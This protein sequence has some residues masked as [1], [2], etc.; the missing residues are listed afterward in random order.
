MIDWWENI[1]FAEQWVLWLLPAVPVFAILLYYIGGRGRPALTLSSFRYL[2]GIR[3]PS[4]VKWRSVLY[5]IRFIIVIVLITAFARPQ[6]RTGF[7]RKHGQGIDIMLC[8]DIS[9][10]METSDDGIGKSSRIESAREQALHFVDQRPD[11]RIGVVIFSGEAFTV[12]PLTTDH[13][14]LKL[15]IGQIDI[16]D[17]SLEQ[18]T[19]IGMGL[20]KAVERIK[21]SKAKSKVIILL[22][23]GENGKGT[24]QPID[25]ARMAKTFGI[26]VYTIGLGASAGKVMAPI[27][28]NPDGSPNYAFQD[29]DIDEQTLMDMASTTGG[30]YFRASDSKNLK[31]VYEEINDLEK[32]DFD[33]N[34]TEQRKEEFLPFLIA[35]L[36]FV[37]LEFSLRYTTFDSL[38]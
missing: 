30:K 20:A 6:S 14:A 3:V 37:L 2:H 10:S 23:D 21:D 29:V 31:H 16:N 19:A 33:K 32:S 27:S 25:A 22:T 5:L 8:I 11:D 35:A 26:R 34:G 24:I 38:T 36:V 17:G 9:T 4:K 15:L 18:G 28:Y 12:C 7:I 1:I 13:E